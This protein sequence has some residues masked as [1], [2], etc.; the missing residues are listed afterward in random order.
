MDSRYIQLA[1]NL[2]GFSVNLKEGERVLIDAYNTRGHGYITSASS[3]NVMV[4]LLFNYRIPQS[5]VNHQR[6][7]QEQFDELAAYELDRMKHD[8][9]LQSVVPVIFLAFLGISSSRTDE[10]NFQRRLAG[11][12]NWRQKTKWVVLRWLSPSGSASIDEYRGLPRFLFRLVRW[13]TKVRILGMKALKKRMDK[14]DQVHISG[15]ETDLCFSIKGIG[16]V[17]CGGTHNIQMAKS[18]LALLEIASGHYP[19]QR[20]LSIKEHLSITSG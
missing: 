12:W 17:S 6:G 5:T 16:V 7:V 13:T 3:A 4:Y 15:D 18:S 8:A 1:R 9:L 11:G 20:P 2:V 19:L 10:Q 14:A